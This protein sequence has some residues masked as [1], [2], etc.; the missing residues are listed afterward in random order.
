MRRSLARELG[1]PLDHRQRRR[2]GLRRDRHDRRAHRRPE[3]R[4]QDPGPAGALRLD[5]RDR[6]TVLWLASDGAAY[7]TGAV[8]PVDG[9]LGMGH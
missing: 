3:E 9:G 2:A 1:S 4:D 8:I 5:G 6:G 7:V